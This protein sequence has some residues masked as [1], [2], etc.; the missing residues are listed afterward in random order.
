VIGIIVKT[1]A[2]VEDLDQEWIPEAFELSALNKAFEDA[3]GYI[4]SKEE[5][6]HDKGD[7]LIYFTI[8]DLNEPRAIT[9]NCTLSG[10][11]AEIIKTIASRLD[12][13]VYDSE[14]CG[15]VDINNV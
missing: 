7:A 11:Q 10:V 1:E 12:A 6:C 9:I 15:F 2:E 14:T 5:F 8:D 13:K 3:I 4:P